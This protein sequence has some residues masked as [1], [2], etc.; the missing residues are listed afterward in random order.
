MS[1]SPDISLALTLLQT[2][3]ARLQANR[4]DARSIGAGFNVF[5]ILG[6]GHREVTTHSPI[7]VELLNPHG[8]HG[9]GAAFLE[10]FLNELGISGF[11][12]DSSSIRVSPE[13]HL[14]PVTENSGGRLDI[15]VRDGFGCTLFIENKIYAGEQENQ[16]SRYHA[17]DPRAHLIYLTLHGSVPR[18]APQGVSV[19]CISYKQHIHRWLEDCETAVLQAP[20]LRE[21]LG[22]YRELIRQITKPHMT[23]PTSEFLAEHIL[24]DAESHAAFRALLGTKP[25]VRRLVFQ[26]WNHRVEAIGLDLGLKL[27]EPMRGDATRYDGWSFTNDELT[28]ANLSIGFQCDSNWGC[29]FR[30]GFKALDHNQPC[31]IAR[32]L[33]QA[34]RSRFRM[35][36]PT[37]YWPAWSWWDA[38]RQLDEAH[39]GDMLFGSVADEVRTLSS[40]LLDLFQTAR[41]DSQL[42]P[43]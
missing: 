38:H 4:E 36:A 23:T 16:L 25:A 33:E 18:T 29:N 30:Y 5:N 37:G 11:R 1:A 12:L 43:T 6:I 22:Q 13:V 28:A 7:L 27:K 26:R 17:H 20:R 14:G 2:A 3:G 10:R 34:F 31:P 19:K 41:S 9:Q 42:S 8:S 32:S 24:N 21:L 35:E 40:S 39:F 15:V